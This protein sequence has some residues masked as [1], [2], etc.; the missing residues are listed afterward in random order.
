MSHAEY[1]WAQSTP[2]IFV[3]TPQ[4]PS[5]SA[6]YLCKLEGSRCLIQSKFKS[7]K[8]QNKISDC[9]TSILHQSFNNINPDPTFPG[10]G[11]PHPIPYSNNTLP[12]L[13][14]DGVLEVTEE[15]CGL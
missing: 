11:P 4:R 14:T 7:Y 3:N 2:E 1:L 9:N 5:L 6:R 12:L 13:T 10:S 15:V 8:R